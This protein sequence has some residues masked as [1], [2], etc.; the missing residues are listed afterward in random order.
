MKFSIESKTIIIG[1]SRY[2]KTSLIMELI[3]RLQRKEGLEIYIYDI[4]HQHQKSIKPKSTEL[5]KKLNEVCRRL[6]AKRKPPRPVLIVDELQTFASHPTDYPHKLNDFREYILTGANY[7]CYLI[8]AT[9][10]PSVAP[11][12]LFANSETK[13]YFHLSRP[14]DLRR[15]ED[16]HGQTFAKRVKTLPKYTYLV[17]SGPDQVV[18]GPFNTKKFQVETPTP[19]IKL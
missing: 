8:G 1:K 16:E 2:G 11:I 17:V 18:S 5:Q 19:P 4:I 9:Q 14:D 3:Q 15:V 7:S 13:V 6:M 12:D 10:R